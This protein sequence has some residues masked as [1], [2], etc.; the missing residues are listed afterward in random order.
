MS[1]EDL[2]RGDA[3]AAPIADIA[4]FRKPAVRRARAE[5][6]SSHTVHYFLALA[7]LLPALASFVISIWA[8]YDE[9]LLLSE[10][11]FAVTGLTVLILAFTWFWGF[12]LLAAGFFPKRG[13]WYIIAHAQLGSV[14]PLLY[15]I[16]FG[17]QLDTFNTQPLG[18]AQLWLNTSALFVLLFQ[19]GGGWFLIDRWP[20][21]KTRRVAAAD[22]TRR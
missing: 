15:M 3:P 13:A 4:E 9:R 21:L 12:Y 6:V 18:D 14:V 17:L 1:A 16:S 7:A 11:A 22:P 5:A 2:G 8:Y 19:I 10:I 20:W